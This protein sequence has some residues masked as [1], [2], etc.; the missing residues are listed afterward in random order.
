[1]QCAPIFSSGPLLVHDTSL[2]ADSKGIPED[3][4]SLD[5]NWSKYYKENARMPAKVN[6]L[7]PWLVSRLEA[8]TGTSQ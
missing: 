2:G 4:A 8:I 7:A 6:E 5:T 3:I 1:M